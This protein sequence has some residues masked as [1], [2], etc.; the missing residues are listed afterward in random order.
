[1]ISRGSKQSCK[2][3]RVSD[4][5]TINRLRAFHVSP[6]FADGVSEV[7]MGVGSNEGPHWFRV[8]PAMAMKLAAELMRYAEGH[9][10]TCPVLEAFR[11]ARDRVK[12]G[13]EINEAAGEFGV[14][15]EMLA[16]WIARLDDAATSQAAA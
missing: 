3:G 14:D 7:V 4:T 12:G 8:K 6:S 15:A 9:S 5:P 1:M 11:G 16:T 13:E 10:E 2:N